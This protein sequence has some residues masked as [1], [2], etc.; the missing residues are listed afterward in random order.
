M[1]TR[2]P[3]KAKTSAELREQLEAAKKRLK[4]LEQRAY[5]EELNELIRGTSIVADF[6]KIQSKVTDIK[7]ATILAAIGHAVG[8]R[9]LT[10]EQASA[11]PRKPADPSKPRKPRASK[12]K[13][14]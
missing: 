3:S 12:S 11:P 8:I 14:A 9:R 10:V 6:A 1:A 13:R 4:D 5:A 2:K 7:P